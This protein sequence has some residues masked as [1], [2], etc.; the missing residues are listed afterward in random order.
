M[1][2]AA[3]A[4]T[5]ATSYLSLAFICCMFLI[6]YSFSLVIVQSISETFL[7][8][9]PLSSASLVI[10]LLA[11]PSESSSNHLTKAQA[12]F[13]WE[14]MVINISLRHQAGGAKGVKYTNIGA[15]L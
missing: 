8:N 2:N 14:I 1:A 5:H 11:L 4:T 9:S 3:T 12:P 15:N 10:T 6:L 13:P 7:F